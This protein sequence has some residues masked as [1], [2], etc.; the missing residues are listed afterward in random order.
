[1]NEVNKVQDGDVNRDIL[2]NVYEHLRAL[3]ALCQPSAHR[4]TK[5]REGGWRGREGNDRSGEGKV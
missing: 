1:M 4:E 5:T 3:K 2:H